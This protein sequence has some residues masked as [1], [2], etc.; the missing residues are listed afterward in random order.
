MRKA[1]FALTVYLY[2]ICTQLYSLCL[3]SSEPIQVWNN[4]NSIVWAKHFHANITIFEKDNQSCL[5]CFSA[6]T[7]SAIQVF[8]VKRNDVWNIILQ[9]GR[10]GQKSLSQV[11]EDYQNYFQI[12]EML[13]GLQCGDGCVL[14]HVT[15]RLGLSSSEKRHTE[16]LPCFCI[17]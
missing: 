11:L 7:L 12:A 5:F 9:R 16:T 10:R 6:F 2:E 8:I 14:L 1:V 4:K 13:L 15:C 17:L 3:C